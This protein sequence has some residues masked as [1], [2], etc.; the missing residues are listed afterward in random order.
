MTCRSVNCST[1]FD[2]DFYFV[3]LRAR[4]GGWRFEMKLE[5]FFEVFKRFLNGGALA[6]DVNTRRLRYKPFVF[7][8]HADGEHLL[9]WRYFNTAG[10]SEGSEIAS[11]S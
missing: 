10:G 3:N 8:A 1:G 9:H 6:G 7:L 11:S 4:N 5:G 2:L